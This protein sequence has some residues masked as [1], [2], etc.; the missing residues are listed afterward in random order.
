MT[1]FYISGTPFITFI[2]L[3]GTSC[4]KEPVVQ[5]SSTRIGNIRLS[6]GFSL[7]FLSNSKT[8]FTV[9]LNWFGENYFRACQNCSF[10][11]HLQFQLYW[12]NQYYKLNIYAIWYH[13][14][15]YEIV[16]KQNNLFLYYYAYCFLRPLK[17]RPSNWTFISYSLN[18]LPFC[19]FS[20]HPSFLFKFQFQ[21]LNKFRSKRGLCIHLVLTHQS[22]QPVKWWT[23]TVYFI[24]IHP[25]LD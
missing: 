1:F 9:I 24:E 6:A 21:M 22:L 3:L 7:P 19:S 8:P 20:L 10:L 25:H 13:I 12:L 18:Q 14:K 4:W 17:L 5:G 11:N 16:Q 23:C 2:V 15:M